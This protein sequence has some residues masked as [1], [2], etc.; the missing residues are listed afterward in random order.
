MSL[1]TWAEPTV[2]ARPMCP[3]GLWVKNR[4]PDPLSP[5]WLHRPIPAS[6]Q[7]GAG[8]DVAWEQEGTTANR[9]RGVGGEGA[10]QSRLAVMKRR[11]VIECTSSHRCSSSG[12]RWSVEVGEACGLVSCAGGGREVASIGA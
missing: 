11:A 9:I 8:A 12:H 2:A 7:S 3:F 10:H 6:Q 4:G 5:S 1:C